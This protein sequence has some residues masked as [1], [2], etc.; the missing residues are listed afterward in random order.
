MYSWRVQDPHRRQGRQCRNSVSRFLYIDVNVS[1]DIM[2][3]TYIGS[4]VNLCDPYF[5]GS[6]PRQDV[7][8]PKGKYSIILAKPTQGFECRIDTRYSG[9]HNVLVLRR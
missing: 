9:G 4:T 3:V 2:R 5:G 7:N 1:A 6:E 8:D